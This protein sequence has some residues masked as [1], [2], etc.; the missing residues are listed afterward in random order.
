MSDILSTLE[1]LNLLTQNESMIFI[2]TL[3][4][5]GKSIGLLKKVLRYKIGVSSWIHKSHLIE[6]HNSLA[7]Q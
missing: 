3:I 2:N 7:A 6:L 1:M 5:E 4:N